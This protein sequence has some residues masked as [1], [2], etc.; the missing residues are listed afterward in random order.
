MNST[1]GSVV[2]LAMFY[3]CPVFF[4]IFVLLVILV[5]VLLFFIFFLF[6]PSY[7][8]SCWFWYLSCCFLYLSWFFSSD[9]SSWWLWSRL[10]EGGDCKMKL[11][12]SPFQRC[13]GTDSSGQ[14]SF[15]CGRSRCWNTFQT[16]LKRDTMR[17]SNRDLF[18]FIGE[19]TWNDRICKCFTRARFQF[20][21]L[22]KVIYY[23]FSRQ[24]R[25]AWSSQT[26]PLQPSSGRSTLPRQP[27][28]ISNKVPFTHKTALEEIKFKIRVPVNYYFADLVCEPPPT[29]GEQWLLKQFCLNHPVEHFQK[30]KLPKLYVRVET[31]TSYFIIHNQFVKQFQF[32]RSTFLFYLFEVAIKATIISNNRL[33]MI[34]A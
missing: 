32:I 13:R 29:M 11:I 7:L 10:P 20:C 27:T 15:R 26:C 34:K 2:P 4:F 8:S 23:Y 31:S 12:R 1:L 33:Q 30:P 21:L 3:I 28:I 25:F 17:P 9:L 6:F 18:S 16:T 22:I 19:Q 14:R 5:F 24:N